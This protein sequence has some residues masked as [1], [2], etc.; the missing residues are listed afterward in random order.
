MSTTW[1]SRTSPFVIIGDPVFRA[2]PPLAAVII[3][4]KP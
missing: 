2:S 4:D 1:R 3:E